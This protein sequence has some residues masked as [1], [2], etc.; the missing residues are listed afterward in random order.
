M[1]ARCEYNRERGTPFSDS[2]RLSKKSVTS[3]YSSRFAVCAT[4]PVTTTRSG[5]SPR[6]RLSASSRTA[7]P[8]RR[9]SSSK[10]R[11]AN[12][13]VQYPPHPVFPRPLPGD[14]KLLADCIYYGIIIDRRGKC[15]RDN[16]Y[17]ATPR[18]FPRIYV[19]SM[20]SFSWRHFR[21]C[22]GVRN[23]VRQFPSALQSALPGSAAKASKRI[24]PLYRNA[25]RLST[26]SNT[27]GLW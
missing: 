14:S 16:G 6:P 27:L 21:V 1:I 10:F 22:S 20:R 2:F 7:C 3:S 25:V 19:F 13:L 24:P 5:R 9:P 26:R 12:R 4:S 11:P 18:D 17:E 8:M 15:A 23:S